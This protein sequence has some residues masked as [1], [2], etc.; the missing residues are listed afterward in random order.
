MKHKSHSQRQ[1]VVLLTESENQQ[2]DYAVTCW[3]SEAAAV[4]RLINIM[5]EYVKLD[6]IVTKP[7][8]KKA[9]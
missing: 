2:N 8:T 6:E 7:E 4:N 1:I 3:I 9:A 5:A